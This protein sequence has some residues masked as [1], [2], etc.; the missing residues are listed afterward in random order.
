MGSTEKAES[1]VSQ[2]IEGFLL[3]DKPAGLTSHDVVARVRRIVGVKRVGHAGTLDP[4]STGLLIV[5]VGRTTRLVR[6]LV[7]LDKEYVAR[8]RLGFATDTQDLT[9]K[10]ITPLK[11][12]NEL[13]VEELTAVLNRFMGPQ[14]QMPPMF[15]AKKVA[16]ERLHRLAREGR[17]VDRA[18]TSVVVR[19]IELLET[20]NSSSGIEEFV[21][22]VTCSS[23]TYIRTL[24]HDIG[25]ALGLGGHLTELRRTKI[26]GFSVEGA[27]RLTRAEE[28]AREGGLEEIL[29]SPAQ[30]LTHLP[31]I[32]LDEERAGWIAHGR[33]V[34]IAGSEAEALKP[35]TAL[36]VLEL[37]SDRLLAIG[38]YD[39][40]RATIRPIVV[41][42]SG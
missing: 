20:G 27:I 7:G 6:F 23:G 32:Q 37:R 4:F 38:E 8:V 30:A 24:G 5:C 16:G 34:S 12:S 42:G 17:V 35:G 28:M 1:R 41:L 9:G 22:R 21:M 11:T 15:S 25:A 10:Q 19:A 2:L 18:P 39:A 31:G 29:V 14:S 26:G 33:Q 13:T 36:R 40:E 3:I